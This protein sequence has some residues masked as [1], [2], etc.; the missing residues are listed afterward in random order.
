MLSIII[1]SI[2]G[3]TNYFSYKEHERNGDRNWANFSWFNIGL[4]S[5]MAFEALVKVLNNL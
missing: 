3:V 1:F 4:C 5:I 2:L